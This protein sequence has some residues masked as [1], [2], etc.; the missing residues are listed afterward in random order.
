[1]G[2]FRKVAENMYSEK[3]LYKHIQSNPTYSELRTQ[4]ASYLESVNIARR[5][6]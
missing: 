1:M 6:K 3:E 4:I 5:S 2:E